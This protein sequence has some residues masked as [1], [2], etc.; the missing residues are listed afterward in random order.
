MPLFKTVVAAAKTNGWGT[1]IGWQHLAEGKRIARSQRKPLMVVIHKKNCP[2]CRK[3][4]SKFASSEQIPSIAEDFVMVNM[5][6]SEAPDLPEF[7]PDGRYIPRI[8]FFSPDGKPLPEI[9]NSDEAYRYAYNDI[10]S[11]VNNM[12]RVRKIVKW[13]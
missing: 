6:W 11:I 13:L 9:K 1:N 7:H 2:E 4:R 8:L 5:E 12:Q 10:E 3:L